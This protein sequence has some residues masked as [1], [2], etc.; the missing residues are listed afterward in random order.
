MWSFNTEI[1]FWGR[2]W[3]W[4]FVDSVPPGRIGHAAFVQN[5]FMYIFGGE[6][7]TQLYDDLWQFNFDDDT[8][9]E[10]VQ[11]GDIPQPIAFFNSSFDG[12]YFY[13]MGGQLDLEN[14]DQFYWDVNLGWIEI[15]FI[16]VSYE[17]FK[18]LL[19]N[20]TWSS[21]AC[22]NETNGECRSFF[23]PVC[24]ETCYDHGICIAD[25]TCLCKGDFTGT[26]CDN[27]VCEWDCYTYELIDSI[28][29]VEA[30]GDLRD[31][32]AELEEKILYLQN[33]LPNWNDF[34]S[35]SQWQSIDLSVVQSVASNGWNFVNECMPDDLMTKLEDFNDFISN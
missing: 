30:L 21:Y 4:E 35:C 25:D 31:E 27:I 17:S 11:S 7:E 19:S 10:I 9:T 14:I 32:L 22:S 29:I 3:N 15:N 24:N 2:G 28:L 33:I 8:W 12:T 5:D 16:D 23:D 26:N 20:F 6:G 13:I 34:Q 1:N 18:L